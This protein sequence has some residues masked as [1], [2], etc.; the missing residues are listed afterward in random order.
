MT[1][2]IELPEDAVNPEMVVVLYSNSEAVAYPTAKVARG[3]LRARGLSVNNF[4]K[5]ENVW[6]HSA[7]S[8]EKFAASDGAITVAQTAPRGP[9]AEGGISKKA[10]KA[11]AK[12]EAGIVVYSLPYR[13]CNVTIVKSAN[14]Y[15][16]F[17]E[18]H[19]GSYS[20][21]EFDGVNPAV[22]H[23]HTTV[24]IQMAGAG[25]PKK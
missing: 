12:A 5:A 15:Q 1:D 23:A 22:E 7:S 21:G 4:Y 25:Y 11:I 18:F 16:A 19:G 24:D 6:G 9:R 14:R 3:A 20:A 13:E 17:Y 10:A 2:P 8:I